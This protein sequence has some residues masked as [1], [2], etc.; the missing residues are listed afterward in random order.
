MKTLVLLIAFCSQAFAGGF[1]LQSN[2]HP[3]VPLT[4]PTIEQKLEQID[5]SDGYS[6]VAFGDQR[7]QAEGSWQAMISEIAELNKEANFLFMMDSGDI[8]NRGRYSDQFH[9]LHDILSPV[10]DLP[11]LVGVGNH[12]ISYNEYPVARENC[13]KFLSY[14]DPSLSAE[15]LYYKKVI[16]DVRYLFLDGTDLVVGDNCEL[17]YPE[18]PVAGSRAEKQLEWLVKELADTGYETTIVSEHFPFLQTSSIHRDEARTL[19]KYKFKD[20]T[21]PD[22]LLNGGVDIFMTGHTH[23]YEILELVRESDSAS[24][25]LVNISGKPSGDPGSMRGMRRRGHDVKGQENS[26]FSERGWDLTGYS[27]TQ[28]QVMTGKQEANQFVVFSVMPNGSIVSWVHYMDAD[29]LRIDTPVML[30]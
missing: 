12:E 11:Y 9:Q 21:F 10:S 8:N 25:K 29:G 14:L 16:G 7:S 19:W 23:T 17:E 22:I 2:E 13:A 5:I 27:I 26:W 18:G 6:F 3:V 20:V 4:H 15:K 24:M 28:H 1:W 30:K